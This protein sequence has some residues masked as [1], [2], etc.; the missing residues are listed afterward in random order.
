MLSNDSKLILTHIWLL[1]SNLGVEEP[2][3][4]NDIDWIVKQTSLKNNE[5]QLD[6]KELFSYG[7]II[8]ISN[9]SNVIQNDIDSIKINIKNIKY[10]KHIIISLQK[11]RY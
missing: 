7:F 8:M 2:K 5:G 6:L 1:A 10:T 9:D 11:S 4:P 3:I